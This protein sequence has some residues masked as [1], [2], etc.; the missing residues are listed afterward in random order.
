[1]PHSEVTLIHQKQLN[2]NVVDPKEEAGG[3]QGGGQHSAD[4]ALAK[5]NGLRSVDSELELALDD[6][7][8][9]TKSDGRKAE[10]KEEISFMPADCLSKPFRDG[11]YQYLKMP[12]G[13]SKGFL[14]L[15][16]K[17]K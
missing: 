3:Y 8:A 7:L 9:Q 14:S 4:K 16:T 10:S 13:T 17:R 11:E 15:Q 12:D 6:I 1:K 5:K 2:R